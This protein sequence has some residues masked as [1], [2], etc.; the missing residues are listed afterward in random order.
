MDLD[1]FLSIKNAFFLCLKLTIIIVS[2]MVVYEFYENSRLYTFSQKI[3][4]RPFAKIGIKSYASI[5]MIV[6]I[7]L[8]IAYGAGVL[9]KNSMS[10]NMSKYEIVLTSLFLSIC[11]AVFEDTLLFVAVGGNGFIILGVRI[12]FAFLLLIMLNMYIAKKHRT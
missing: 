7:V 8:G 4:S 6:G 3:L 5:T 1:I 2:L 11:H 10:G 12:A 9:I